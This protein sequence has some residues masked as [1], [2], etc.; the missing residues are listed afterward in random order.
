MNGHCD[1]HIY[2]RYFKPCYIVINI[3]NKIAIV[4]TREYIVIN[5]PNKIAIVSTRE[6][7]L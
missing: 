7:I 4:S 6:Y 5:I 1:R 3:P 2:E